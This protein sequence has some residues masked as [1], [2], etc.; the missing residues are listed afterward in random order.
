M[1]E[2]NILGEKV[3]S[4]LDGRY[5]NKVQ[6]L[7]PIFS[8]FGLVKQRVRVEVEYFLSLTRELQVEV[9]QKDADYLYSLVA[10]FSSRDYERVVGIERKI[11]HDVKA[12]EYWLGEK[13]EARNRGEWKRW[14]HYGLTS[15]DV[16]NLAQSMQLREGNIVLVTYLQNMGEE[17]L[18]LAERCKGA[19]MLART[20]GQ[21]AVPTLMSK[22]LM[23][24]VS[25]LVVMAE[26][27][28]DYQ[29]QGK[30]MGA[31]GTL[32]AHKA[33]LPEIDWL[34]FVS[35]VVTSLG[36][37]PVFLTTQVL[38]PQSWVGLF[39][40]WQRLALVMRSLAEDLWWYVSLD[41][42]GQRVIRRE[43]G[44]STMPQK[45]N[46]I[47][48]EN[49]E[50][51]A[52][53]AI[54]WFGLFE[55]K[56]SHSRLQRDLS[57]STVRRNF[58]VAYGHMLLA[59]RSLVEGLGRLAPR[60]EVM[61]QELQQYPE[62]LAEVYQTYL[63]KMGVSEDGYSLIK[64]VFR[65]GNQTSQKDL[66]KLWEKWGLGKETSDI[67]LTLTPEAYLGYAPEL[68]EENLVLFRTR[69]DRLTVDRGGGK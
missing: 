16:N 9:G 25:Q 18:D 66:G 32:A 43:V 7:V 27:I 67:L 52:A 57:D 37:E 6:E 69:L 63:R 23:V 4:P 14:V 34:K 26:E 64:D 56:F 51:N 48:L 65:G 40:L 17:L 10:D 46:P 29:F 15:E 5:A 41:Y 36:F 1:R 24:Y 55:Q 19:V 45:V 13:L 47:Q 2:M 49:A 58:G 44:S 35:K 38:T 31:V 22:E 42:F 12:V 53:I 20:H 33:T 54:S 50:G 68:V 62:V 59:I 28:R 60:T 21:A 3:I 8:D 11:N 61:R 30:I 39:S